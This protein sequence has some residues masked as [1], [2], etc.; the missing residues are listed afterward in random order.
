MANVSGSMSMRGVAELLIMSAFVTS[1]VGRTASTSRRNPSDSRRPF[2]AAAGDTN[3]TASDAAS[4]ATSAGRISTGCGVGIDAFGSPRAA[5]TMAPDLRTTDGRTPKNLGSHSTR[6]ASLPGSIDPT[7][8]SMPCATAGLI[9]YFATYRRARS[10][11]AGSV[12]P[13]E[14]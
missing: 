9:V 12:S 8:W 3:D 14:P 1:R 7:R 2:S 4:S 10:L 6:S 13:S 11:S 5:H